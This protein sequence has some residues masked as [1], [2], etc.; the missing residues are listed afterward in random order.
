MSLDSLEGSIESAI[1]Y[2]QSIRENI[3]SDVQIYLSTECYGDSDYQYFEIY[4]SRL[5]TNEEYEKRMAKN[6]NAK[7]KKQKE[8]EAAEK[9]EYNRYLELKEK[10]EQR[11]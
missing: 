9:A 5:E 8:K 4:T 11:N 6:K 7:V 10:Y 2:L 3:P 1:E